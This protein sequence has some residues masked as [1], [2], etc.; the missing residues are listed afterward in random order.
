MYRNL[1]FLLLLACFACEGN[2]D[3]RKAARGENFVPDPNRI[4]FQNTRVRHYLAEEVT[5]RA[6]IY[7]HDALYRSAAR[8]LP[9]LVDDWLQ[10]RAYLRFDTRPELS[11]WQLE[12][13]QP[14][15]AARPLALSAPPTNAELTALSAALL[16]GQ[17]LILRSTADSLLSAFP[18][19]EGRAEARRVINDYLALVGY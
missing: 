10:D 14:D 9:V 12:I 7:R 3:A 8:L 16:E 15:E 4:Y 13:H 18:S 19:D 6:V 2:T 11:S 17:E 1:L 5:D